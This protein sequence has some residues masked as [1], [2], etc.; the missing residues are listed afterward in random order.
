MPLSWPYQC[1]RVCTLIRVAVQLLHLKPWATRTGS[2]HEYYF[3]SFGYNLKRIKPCFQTQFK[4]GNLDATYHVKLS[5]RPLFPSMT[6][7]LNNISSQPRRNQNTLVN[8][9]Y[10]GDWQLVVGLGLVQL[11]RSKTYSKNFEVL[12]LGSTSKPC[13]SMPAYQSGK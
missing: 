8:L 2:W 7:L 13:L 10:L 1:P 4:P 11:G 6:P 5:L 3:K 9:I 12:D